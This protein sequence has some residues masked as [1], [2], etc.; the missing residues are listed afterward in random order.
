MSE[1]VCPICLEAI[2]ETMYLTCDKHSIHI[3][4]LNNCQKLDCPICRKHLFD[5]ESRLS[6]DIEIVE[7]FTDNIGP[8]S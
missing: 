8:Y 3:E 1:E 5:R 6:N 7:L 2:G 4:C